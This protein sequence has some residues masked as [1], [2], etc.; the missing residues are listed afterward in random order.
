M[1]IELEPTLFP[2]LW[3]EGREDLKSEKH[4]PDDITKER[5]YYAWTAIR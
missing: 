5:G 4:T 3:N 1:L 2:D